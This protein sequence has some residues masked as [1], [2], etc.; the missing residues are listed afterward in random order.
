MPEIVLNNL[1][2]LTQLQDSF[3]M[4]MV[5]L[6]DGQ[7][8]AAQ[9]EAVPRALHLRTGAKSSR[10]ARVFELRKARER[11]H[12][13]EG[14]AVALSNVDE[15]IA[16]IKASPTPAEA[17]TALMARAWRSPLVEE[18]LKRAAADAARPEGLPRE[19]G[20]HAN[21]GYRLSDAQAQAILELRL[22]RLTG[23]EQDKITRRVPRGDDADRR[24]ARHPRQAR[25]RHADHPRRARPPSSDQFGD[26]R[27]SEIVAQGED[28]STRG[29]DRAARTWWSRC[30]TAAT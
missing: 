13:L 6:V 17:K 14:L 21:D 4:N 2:K 30:R 27:R 29:P 25:A 28:L 16:L 5:A 11:G 1:Y 19:F 15:I 22:Q 7:P 12:V 10:G 24:P 3:G 20:W 9:P 8:R 23:L 26:K 18:M